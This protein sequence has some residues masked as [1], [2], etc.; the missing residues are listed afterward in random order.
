MVR[1]CVSFVASIFQVCRFVV[2]ILD[3]KKK[4]EVYIVDFL[5]MKDIVFKK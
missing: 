4:Q 1:V 5:L 2:M 3:V